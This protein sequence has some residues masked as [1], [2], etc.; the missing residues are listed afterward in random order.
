MFQTD[1]EVEFPPGTYE[2]TI[3]GCLNNG[4]TCETTK[5]DIELISPCFDG[6]EITITATAQSSPDPDKYTGELIFY[7]HN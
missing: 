4:Q 1:D 6:N 2:I 7:D 3:Q 5:F